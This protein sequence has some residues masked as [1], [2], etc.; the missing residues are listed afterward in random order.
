MAALFHPRPR[1]HPPILQPAHARLRP[2]QLTLGALTGPGS[3]Y[4]VWQW[5]IVDTE[6][7]ARIHVVQQVWVVCW[8]ARPQLPSDLFSLTPCYDLPIKPKPGHAET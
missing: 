6:Q 4:C 5:S 1:P 2:T 7:S 3:A 8:R